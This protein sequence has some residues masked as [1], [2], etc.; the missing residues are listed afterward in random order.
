MGD[1]ND[2]CY[3]TWSG[4]SVPLFNVNEYDEEDKEADEVYKYFDQYMDQRRQKRRETKLK[5]TMK[6]LQE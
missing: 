4:Y 5:E 3:D 2:S 1:Y 6:K